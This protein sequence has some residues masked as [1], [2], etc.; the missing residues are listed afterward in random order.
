M[1]AVVL[2]PQYMLKYVNWSL[3]E[4]YYI[5]DIASDLKKKLKATLTRLYKFYLEKDL[6][7]AKSFSSNKNRNKRKVNESLSMQGKRM[8][9][10]KAH[11]ED[12]KTREVSELERY[13]FFPDN[14]WLSYESFDLLDW[15]KTNEEKYNILGKIA[16]DVLVAPVSIV[17]L[18]FAFSMGSGIFC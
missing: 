14:Q 5:D 11:L 13:F 8:L 18:E 7:H 17:A 16:R 4:T 3:E 1:Q 10:Y 2:D 9:I 6:M 15:W 12:N